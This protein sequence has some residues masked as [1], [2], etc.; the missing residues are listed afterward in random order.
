ME[1]DR[2]HSGRKGLDVYLNCKEMATHQ[3]IAKTSCWQ[4][5]GARND[6]RMQLR[7]LYQGARYLVFVRQKR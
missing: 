1:P 2:Q 6:T 4:S 5:P 7:L 3:P